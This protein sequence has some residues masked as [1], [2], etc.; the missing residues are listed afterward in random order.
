MTYR[1]ELSCLGMPDGLELDVAEL[2]DPLIW[3][4]VPELTPAMMINPDELQPVEQSA[5]RKRVFYL[6]RHPNGV[7]YH[8]D[9]RIVYRERQ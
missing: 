6:V 4:D 2:L 8:H 9:G 3:A 5:V 7:P 1:A